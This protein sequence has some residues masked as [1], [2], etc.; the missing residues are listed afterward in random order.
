MLSGEKELKVHQTVPQDAPKEIVKGIGITS[1]FFGICVYI[2]FL[3]FIISLLIPIPILFYRLK[4]G[5]KNGSLVAAGTFLVISFFLGG[6]SY[7]I[8]FFAQLLVLGLVFGEMFERE[9]S[10]E[11]II[12]YACLTLW[13][14]A[15]AVLIFASS[16]S[17]IQITVLISDFVGKNL[18]LSL[19]FYEKMG[20]PQEHIQVI[21]DSSEMIQYAL[22]RI[23]PG[24]ATAGGLFVAWSNLLVARPVLSA[25]KIHSPDFG[26]LKTW[27]APE[28]LVW[29][30]IGCGIML[31]VPEKGIRI[32]G[33]NGFFI[34]MTIYFFQGIAIV[35]FFF[36]KKDVPMLLRVI[37]YGFIGM[38]FFL[39]LMVIAAGFFDMWLDLRKLETLKD[40]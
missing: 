11:K 22:V 6:F 13:A 19:D 39:I 3:G 29:A 15:S 7:N 40:Q 17:G 33:L 32:F 18:E 31:L 8:F 37:L 24:M 20:V 5:R 30:A 27:K 10:V 16:T 21:Q 35:S 23:I 4:L 1:L 34:L 25:A 2:P 38:Q 9:M 12:L 28:Q 36:D 26:H 14:T